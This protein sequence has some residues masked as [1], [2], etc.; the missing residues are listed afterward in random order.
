MS[1]TTKMT[2]EPSNDGT[3][4]RISY[5]H[6]YSSFTQPFQRLVVVVYSFVFAVCNRHECMYSDQC[7]IYLEQ[8]NANFFFVVVVVMNYNIIVYVQIKNPSCVMRT[9]ACTHYL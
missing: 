6:H 5:N 9:V 3:A 1:V 7:G 8:Q 4:G 2:V